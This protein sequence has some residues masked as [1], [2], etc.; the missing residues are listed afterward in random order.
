MHLQIK[1]PVNGEDRVT[2]L[3]GGKSSHVESPKEPIAGVL[4]QGSLA[5]GRWAEGPTAAYG[6]VKKASI[7]GF[8]RPLAEGLDVEA[9]AFRDVFGSA[10][11]RE[12]VAA[13]LEKRKATFKGS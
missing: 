3:F 5:A 2:N 6:A 4:G 12:G 1:R 10:D 9:E 8:G 13:F 11:A 7:G